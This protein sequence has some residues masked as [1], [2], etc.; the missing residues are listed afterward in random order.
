M[1][2]KRIRRHLSAEDTGGRLVRLEAWIDPGEGS[3]EEHRHPDRDER[4]E[5][6]AGRLEL[7]VEGDRSVLLAGD[8]GLAP[9]GARHSW[10]NGGQGE[11]HLFVELRA[12]SQTPPA[13]RVG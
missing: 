8:C 3:P 11:L 10:R 1:T 5:V 13:R 2:G 12:R 9:A 7:D 4:L 6:L